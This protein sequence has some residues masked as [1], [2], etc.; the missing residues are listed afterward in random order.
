[1]PRPD[2]ERVAQWKRRRVVCDIR[3]VIECLR[4]ERK[5]TSDAWIDSFARLTISNPRRTAATNPQI[6]RFHSPPWLARD[7][8]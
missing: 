1:M 2:V 4:G 8:L 6:A 5:Y 3:C 7:R